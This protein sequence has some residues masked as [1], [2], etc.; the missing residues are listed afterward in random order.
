M[1]SRR[2][3]TLI[4]LLVVI[5]IIGILIALLLP[6]VQQAREAARRTQ[7]R[8]H[9]HQIG[10]ALHNYHSTH[11]L[12]PPTIVNNS[13]AGS[14][15][16]SWQGNPGVSAMTL[17]LPYIDQANIYNQ[18][19]F[20]IGTTRSDYVGSPVVG[21]INDTLH[22]TTIPSLACPSDPNLDIQVTGACVIIIAPDW[23]TRGITPWG[24]IN[25]VFCAGTTAL[26]DFRA[27]NAAGQ[28]TSPDHLGIFQQNGNRGIRDVLD[29]TSNTLMIGEVL[30]VDHSNN[31]PGNG[32]GGKPHW[33][34]GVPTQMSFSTAGGINANWRA[35]AGAPGQCRGPNTTSGSACG[36]ARHAALQSQHEG[37]CTVALADGS[38][39]FISENID[40][41]LLNSL[42]TCQTSETVGEF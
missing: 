37:G 24:G 30:W 35:Y 8:N 11:N 42:A 6:A 12:F 4:E 25:Y 7:C 28:F 41:N 16:G 36:G 18:Y 1:K 39:R 20:T 15:C 9:L 3:F 29:G 34:T 14:V 23:A 13:A 38:A 10:L 17:L 31:P 5:A 40:Q 32:T 2:G 27:A 26:Y 19:N 33:A 22:K 21:G